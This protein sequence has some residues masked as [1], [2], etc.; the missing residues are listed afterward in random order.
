MAL[1]DRDCIFQWAD[2]PRHIESGS[3]FDAD[4]IARIGQACLARLLEMQQAS[5][6]AAQRL[7]QQAKRQPPALA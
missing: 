3:V 2:V 1:A 4:L 7:R 6:S 5:S